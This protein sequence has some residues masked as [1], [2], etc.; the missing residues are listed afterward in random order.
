MPKQKS[1][2]FDSQG[3]P[4]LKNSYCVFMDILGFSRLSQK[5]FFDG[6]GEPLLI[7]I[8][9]ALTSQEKDF[10]P[11]SSPGFPP[12]WHAKFFT[13][14]L[15]VGQ[16]ITSEDGESEF[17]FIILQMMIYQARLAM[18][19]LFVRGGVSIGDLFIDDNTVFGPSLI[20]AYR[21]ESQIAQEPRILLSDEVFEILKSQMEYYK[22]QFD[23]PQNNHIL[24]D[25]DGKPFVNYLAVLFEDSDSTE[26]YVTP[27]NWLKVH[28]KH[29]EQNLVDYQDNPY[30]WSKYKWLAEYHNFFCTEYKNFPEFGY[31]ENALINPDLANRH[32]SRI[33]STPD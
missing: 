12:D 1:L 16:I 7:K 31:D 5:A 4:K 15:V 8:H 9:K 26:D 22:H 3:N 18:E 14:N 21:I 28:K 6:Q 33:I 13:D 17:G 2:Y 25:S 27:W 20:Q 24:I 32:P 10:T 11:D 23:S 29:I 19:G 30:V